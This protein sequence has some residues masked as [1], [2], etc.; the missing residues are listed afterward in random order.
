MALLLTSI[1]GWLVFFCEEVV[2]GQMRPY[3][4]DESLGI[5]YARNIDI[6]FGIS[7]PMATIQLNKTILSSWQVQQVK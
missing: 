7:G 2:D 3:V 1:M 5:R 6:R 4:R